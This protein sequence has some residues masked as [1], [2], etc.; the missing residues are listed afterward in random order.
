MPSIGSED[1]P[2]DLVRV[3]FENVLGDDYAFTICPLFLVCKRWK[4]RH[5]TT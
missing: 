3:V 5:F 2:E 1:F 4:V